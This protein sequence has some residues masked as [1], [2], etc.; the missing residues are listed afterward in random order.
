[1]NPLVAMQLRASTY[2][3]GHCAED[4]KTQLFDRFFNLRFFIP[5]AEKWRVRSAASSLKTVGT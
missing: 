5:I 3:E 1:M 4:V 2:V